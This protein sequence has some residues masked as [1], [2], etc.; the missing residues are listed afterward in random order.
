MLTLYGSTPT[1]IVIGLKKT[2]GVS[3]AG[4]IFSTRSRRHKF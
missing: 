2:F 4:T 1:L 3:V